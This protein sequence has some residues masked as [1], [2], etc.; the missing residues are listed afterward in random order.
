MAS[1]RVKFIFVVSK[2]TKY[3]KNTTAISLGE[4]GLKRNFYV[5]KSSLIPS[6]LFCW[7][8]VSYVC[9][10]HWM[11]RPIFIWYKDIIYMMRLYERH[12]ICSKFKL[13]I[14]FKFIWGILLIYQYILITIKI[15]NYINK[16]YT[17]LQQ[18]SQTCG[19]HLGKHYNISRLLWLQNLYVCV[20]KIINL[21]NIKKISTENLS[22]AN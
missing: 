18:K 6:L 15:I 1:C 21:Y 7:F 4:M 13:K 2:L 9:I 17:W 14:K 10:M 3:L 22:M 8:V 20:T 11:S 19:K 5:Q 16:K 12:K